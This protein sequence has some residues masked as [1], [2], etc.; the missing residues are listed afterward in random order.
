[1][2][3]LV[4]LH[5][6]RRRFTPQNASYSAAHWLHAGFYCSQEAAGLQERSERCEPGWIKI[7]T[8]A[9]FF[10][11]SKQGATS[12]VIRDERR[13]FLTGQATWHDRAF[14][15]CSMEAAACRDGLKLAGRLGFQRVNLETD[16][17]SSIC[18]A[19]EEEGRA[20]ITH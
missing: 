11:E 14:D 16:L 13:S 7:N 5:R 8:D 4:R 18:A 3:Y 9:A 17:L 12:C 10:T 6:P 19:L 2:S 1:M 20:T 15:A